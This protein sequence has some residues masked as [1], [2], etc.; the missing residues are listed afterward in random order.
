[1]SNDYRHEVYLFLSKMYKAE[2]SMEFLAKLTEE[3]IASQIKASLESEGGS[4]EEG[5]RSLYE[6]LGASRHRDLRE[7]GGELAEEYAS[8]FFGTQ[9]NGLHPSES[10]YRSKDHL[11]MQEAWEQV[12]LAYLKAGVGKR[13]S[14]SEPE[15]HITVEL[16]FMGFLCKKTA[17]ALEK[18]HYRAAKN[19]LKIQK[20]FIQKHLGCWIPQFAEDV[21]RRTRSPFYKSLASITGG[22]IEVERTLVNEF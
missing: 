9:K 11:I 12:A 4:M 16:E 7:V 6:Y 18:K 20:E 17:D 14:Y 2:I 5:A 22:F 1:M 10:Y 3:N 15:D 19:C 21:A 13:E 8:L